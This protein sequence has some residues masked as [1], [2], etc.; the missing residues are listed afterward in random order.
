MTYYTITARNGGAIYARAYEKRAAAADV[1]EMLR[2]ISKGWRARVQRVDAP[3][4]V[5]ACETARKWYCNSVAFRI[6]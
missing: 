4:A 1:A 5:A 3:D 2:R 6:K